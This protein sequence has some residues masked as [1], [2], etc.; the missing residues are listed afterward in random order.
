MSKQNPAK[1]YND[2][3]N[4]VIEKA[5]I[6]RELLSNPITDFTRDRKLSLSTML[7]III[8]SQGGS[9]NRELYD[10]D[11]T[12]DVTSS[13]FI[14]QR[15]KILPDMFK[16]IFYDFNNACNDTN[17]YKGYK[18]FA[19]DGSDVNIAYNPNSETYVY[20][21]NDSKGYNQFHINA[22][23]DVLNKTYKDCIIQPKP[24]NDEVDACNQVVIS[25]AFEKA[26]LLA[27]RGY[28]ALNL[29]ETIRRKDNLDYL[30]RVKNEWLTETKNLPLENLDT[31]ITFE[32][33]TTATKK[34]KQLFKEGKAKWISGKSKFGKSKKH[35]SWQYESP[36]IMTL[37]IVRF[38]IAENSYE[39]IVTSLDRDEF[40]LEEIKK[41]YHLR[42][43]IETSFREL[44]YAI[45]LVNFHA[46]KESAIIQEI[47]A[48]LVMYNLC[49]RIIMNV[50]IRQD[51]KRKW[52]Y[53]V[54]YT[55]A[56]HICRNIYRHHSNEPPPDVILLISKY[57]LP[58]RPDRK[59]ERK[60]RTKS[61]V[62]F[63]Y[64]VA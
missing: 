48:K 34:D 19:V 12:I 44:K 62:Y 8:S 1:Y 29:L 4:N 49:Q 11:N 56:I 55:M 18:L 43:G 41:L 54:N 31:D 40:P 21:K 60:M 13:A 64:R 15:D 32:L 63:L 7:K 20:N 58:V 9:I 42:W 47:F 35:I 33:R 27:D 28:G 25:N 37:R 2:I 26:I 52:T 39:T 53:Q 50:V 5:A 17:T 57:I 45:G 61:V 16:S 3:L 36:Y 24:Q 30:I 51:K 23:Y 59:D 46:K 14:Q 22:L 38:E 10:Y 6:H